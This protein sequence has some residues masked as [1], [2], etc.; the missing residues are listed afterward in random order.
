MFLTSVPTVD[1]GF[2]FYSEMMPGATTPLTY[3][4]FASAIDLSCLVRRI[5]ICSHQCTEFK[6]N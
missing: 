6:I 3:S 5:C 2:I 1:I 4:V